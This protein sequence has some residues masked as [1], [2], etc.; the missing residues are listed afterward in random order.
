MGLP[1][2]WGTETEKEWW[3]VL[4]KKLTPGKDGEE[5]K[6]KNDNHFIAAGIHLCT[7]SFTLSCAGH[8]TEALHTLTPILT[9][10]LP[11]ATKHP[12]FV[13]WKVISD[14]LSHTELA[15]GGRIRILTQCGHKAHT[16]LPLLQQGLGRI[17][18]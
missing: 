18:G 1:G 14:L 4:S 13:D 6:T 3:R 11:G 9:T 17:T 10:S 2:A 7:H 15:D 16:L 5:A 12:G 8:R